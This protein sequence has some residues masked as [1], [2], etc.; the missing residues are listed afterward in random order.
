MKAKKPR[1]KKRG[2]HPETEKQRK[3][4][5]EAFGEFLSSIHYD[6][7]P[8]PEEMKKFDDDTAELD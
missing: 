4:S 5:E 7:M 8:T 6:R 3:G 1:R 2:S